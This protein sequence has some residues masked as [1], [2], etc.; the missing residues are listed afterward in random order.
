MGPTAFDTS[1]GLTLSKGTRLV[2]LSLAFKC[3]GRTWCWCAMRAGP[4]GWLPSDSLELQCLPVVHS[5]A[6]EPANKASLNG[7]LSELAEAVTDFDGSLRGADFITFARGCAIARLPSSSPSDGRWVRGAVLASS[8]G[9]F[10]ADLISA[11]DA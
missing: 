4:I 6:V 9:L 1:Y 3:S 10:P 2:R 7:S 11:D 8:A 5:E